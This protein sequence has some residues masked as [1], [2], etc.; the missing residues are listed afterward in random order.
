MIVI[1]LKAWS[2]SHGTEAA[3]NIVHYIHWFNKVSRWVT[4]E[5]IKGNTPQE[6]SVI[7]GKWIEIG[8]VLN[9]PMYV[10]IF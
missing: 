9:M 2:K 5:I 10:L 1:D 4:T 7:I 8:T 3:P 6:R